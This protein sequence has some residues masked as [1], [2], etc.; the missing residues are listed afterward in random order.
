MRMATGKMGIG[1]DKETGTGMGSRH[2]G[3]NGSGQLYMQTNE[4]HNYIVHYHRAADGTITEAERLRTGG[5]GSG[6]FK[7]I[8]GQES[9]PNAFE[10]AASVILSPDR[11]F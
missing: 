8:S 2:M 7:P 3:T 4:L 1:S 5:A 6:T 9:A 10:G 11:R